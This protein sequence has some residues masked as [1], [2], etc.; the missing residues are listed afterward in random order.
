MLPFLPVAQNSS[1]RRVLYSLFCLLGIMDSKALFNWHEIN[2]YLLPWI[3]QEEQHSLPGT[4]CSSKQKAC[5]EEHCSWFRH[6]S[7]LVCGSECWGIF[8]IS[9]WMEYPSPEEVLLVWLCLDH[10]SSMIRI[11]R[12]GGELLAPKGICLGHL[13]VPF[14]AESM[15]LWSS[16]NKGWEK[17]LTTSAEWSVST[18]WTSHNCHQMSTPTFHYLLIFNPGHQL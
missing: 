9:L 6:G 8:G 12:Q 2:V 18:T 11:L 16:W 5:W 15:V 13:I 4:S 7:P 10:S 14:L 17:N 1:L 3:P